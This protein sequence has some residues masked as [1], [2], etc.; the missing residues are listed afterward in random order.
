MVKKVV[1]DTDIGID[2]D[3]AVALA[4]LLEKHVKR[5]C[6]L[7][8]VTACSTRNG[9]TE[10]IKAI[11]NYYNVNVEIGKMATP[12]LSCDDINS[13]ATAVKTKFCQS[14]ETI[15]AVKLLRKKLSSLTEKVT[16]I[17]IGPLVNVRRFLESAPDEISNKSGLELAR[18]KIEALY[19]M[20]G[21]FI[22]N[23]GVI[24][25]PAEELFAEWNILQDIKS[26]QMVT[27][28]FPNE[29]YFIPW[30]AG[31]EVYSNMGV[32]NNPVWYAMEQHAIFLG[33][34]TNGYKRDSWDPITC[35]L[36][37]EN[38]GDYFDFSP[39]G[40]VTVTSDGVTKFTAGEGKS[41]I[42]LLKKQ[43]KE[44]ANV[45]NSKLRS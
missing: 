32:G 12:K 19:V 15:D 16:F 27:E 9:A 42:L 4:L 34:E 36:A 24:K 25:K 6:E 26:A 13:Y 40:K 11:C 44:I 38:C 10:T 14:V 41:H 2:C 8:L 30:E 29:I 23:Y 33:V 5:E 7:T 3:D 17:A 21:S 1:L 20:G 28:N 35:L 22:E 43:Y 31:F 39:S 37:T 18:E 45:I